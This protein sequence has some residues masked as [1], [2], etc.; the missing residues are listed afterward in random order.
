MSETK[1]LN[2]IHKHSKWGEKIEMRN[3]QKNQ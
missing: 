3:K 1:T 2:E